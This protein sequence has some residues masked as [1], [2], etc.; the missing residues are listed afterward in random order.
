MIQIPIDGQALPVVDTLMNELFQD[1][2]FINA[3]TGRFPGD[4]RG[5]RLVQIP[6][7]DGLRHERQE[8]PQNLPP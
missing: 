2:L 6:D 8:P 5:A 4:P 3:A 7:D 1:R